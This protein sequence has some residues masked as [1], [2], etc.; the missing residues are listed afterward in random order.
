MKRLLLTL[1]L[2][3]AVLFEASVLPS[4]WP[5]VVQPQ[6]LLMVILSLEFADQSPWSLY[7]AFLGGLLRDL[8]AATAI[9]FSSLYLVLIVGAVGLSRRRL[10]GSLLFLFTITFLVS[11]AFRFLSTLPLL[12]LSLVRLFVFGGLLDA[13]LMLILFPT[14][15]YFFRHL[16]EK[17]ELQVGV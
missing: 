7:S 16:F 13:G 14:L 6:L 9:G 1:F 11:F 4:L 15:K 12:D 17:K 2:I 10:G 8:L 5:F 3:V